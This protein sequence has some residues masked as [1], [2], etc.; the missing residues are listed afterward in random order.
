[1]HKHE[2]VLFS[3][4]NNG[5]ANYRISRTGRNCEYSIIAFEQ[6]AGYRFLN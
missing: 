2:R 6:L 5:N 4:N 3:R 1:M